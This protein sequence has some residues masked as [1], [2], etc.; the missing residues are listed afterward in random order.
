MR[1]DVRLVKRGGVDDE[2]DASNACPD[3]IPVHD[4]TDMSCKG[5]IEEIE[6]HHLVLAV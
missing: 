4:R 2:I 3:E 1:R 5:R 6:S